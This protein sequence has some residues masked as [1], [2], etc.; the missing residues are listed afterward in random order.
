MQEALVYIKSNLIDTDGGMYL[1]VNSLIKVNNVIMGSNNITLRK[2]NI[3]PY[4]FDKMF[5]D[6]ELIENKLYQIIDQFNERKI[7]STKFYSILLNK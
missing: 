1:K 5:M 7:T 4:G 6:K 3:K 2:V